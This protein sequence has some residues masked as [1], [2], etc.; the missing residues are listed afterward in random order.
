MIHRLDGLRATYANQF[1]E[2][3]QKQIELSKIADFRI[4]QSIESLNAFQ[5]FG[6]SD[7]K[8]VIIYN[9]ADHNVFKLKE[10][11]KLGKKIKLIANSWSTNRLKGFDT[12]SLMSEV[13]GVE[14]SFIGRWNEEVPKRNVKILGEKTYTEVAKSLSECDFFLHAASNDPCPNVVVEA[15]SVGLPV[16][17]HNSGGTKELAQN[18]GVSLPDK[19]NTNNLSETLK[20]AIQKYPKLVE[21]IKIDRKNFSIE[22]ATQEYISIF[23]NLV[24]EKH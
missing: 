5:K 1:I 17:Y 9:G 3:D 20:L 11:F 18:Y 23:K 14:M 22:R 4:F 19:I 6:Y 8:H 2:N 15:L 24:N 13:P 7:N 10:D 16:I 12:I 21:K